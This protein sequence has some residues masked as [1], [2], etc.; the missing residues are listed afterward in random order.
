[1]FTFTGK[2]MCLCA[3][4]LKGKLLFAILVCFG[5]VPLLNAQKSPSQ[6]LL[7]TPPVVIDQNYCI[8]EATPTDICFS[9]SDLE[10]NP[11]TMVHYPG[12]QFLKAG[13]EIT[14]YSQDLMAST[15]TLSLN[16]SNLSTSYGFD[17]ITTYTWYILGTADNYGG[18]LPQ[19]PT[20][21]ASGSDVDVTGITP[22]DDFYV[23]VEVSNGTQSS[24]ASMLYGYGDFVEGGVIFAPDATPSF[25][26]STLTWTDNSDLFEANSNPTINFQKVDEFGMDTGGAGATLFPLFLPDPDITSTTPTISH[27]YGATTSYSSTFWSTDSDADPMDFPLGAP[28]FCSLFYEE[29]TSF[30]ANGTISGISTTSTEACFTYTPDPGFTGT[31]M[32]YF[33][34]CD[35]EGACTTVLVEFNVSA[36][37]PALALG[38]P[39]TDPTTCTGS[40]GVIT[41]DTSNIIDGSY[42]VNYTD[43][44]GNLQTTSMTVASDVGTLSGLAVGTYDNIKLEYGGCTTTS[45]IDVTLA[46]PPLPDATLT[47]SDPTTT[48]TESADIV[49]SNSEIGV[50]Y[51]LRLNSDNSNVG[52]PQAGTGGDLIFTVNPAVSTGYNILAT[53]DGTDCSAQLDDIGDVTVDTDGDGVPDHIDLDDDNDGI[54]DSV[55]DEN[56]DGDGDPTTNPTDTDSDGIPDYLDL[57]SDNDGI[58]DIIEAQTTTG[59]V[60]PNADTPTDYTTNNGVNSALLGGLTPED[61][62]GDGTP[63]YLD[64]DS[65][66]DGIFDIN[67]SGSGLVDA[68]TDGRTDGTVGVNGL[69]NTLDSGGTDDY[70]DVNGSFD[71]TQT[72][73]FTDTN[74][75]AG[76][77]GDVDYRELDASMMISQ[78]YNSSG[79]RAVELT[80]IGP[81]IVNTFVVAIFQDVSGDLTGVTP[82][83]TLTYTAGALSTFDS[84]VFQSTGFT[85]SNINNTPIEQT[86][87]NI[88]NFADGNDVIILTTTTDGTAWANRYDVIESFANNTSYVRNDD[89]LTTSLTF[90]ASDW[91]AFVDDALDPYRDAGSGGP[92]RHPHDPLLSEVQNSV[93]DRNQGLGY[94]RTNSTGITGGAWGNGEPDRSRRVSILEDYNHS[95]ST[96][97]ARRLIVDDDVTFSM[98]DNAIMV[99]ETITLSNSNSEIRLIG[100]S[101]LITTHTNTS[102]VSGDGRLLVD[103]NSTNPS[104]YRYNYMGSPVNTIGQTTFTVADVMKDGTV[105]TSVSSSVTD[106]NFISGFDG[107]GA[108]TPVS[109]AEYWIYSFGASA[110]WLQEMSSGTIPETDGFIF[111]GPGQTQN[112]TFAGTPK[113]GTMQTTVAASTSYLL[114][115]PFASAISTKKFIEDNLIATTG[116][117]YFW[118][119]KENINGEEDIFGHYYN[120][121]VGGYAIRNLSM[122]LAANAVTGGDVSTGVAGLGTGP[123]TEPA[124]YIAIG[125][126]FFIGGSGTG[127]TVEFNNSQ[128]EYIIE[129]PNS[130]FI[131]N[132]T[133]EENPYE[134]TVGF[135]LGMTYILEEEDYHRQIGISFL[136]TNSF[137]F[138]KGYDAEAFDL[139]ATDIYWDFPGDDTPYFIAGV[140][141]VHDS[142]QVPLTIIMDYDGD[143]KLTID[144][145]S[146]IHRDI[147]L[148]D[149]VDDITYTLGDDPQTLNLTLGIYEDRFFI[150]FGGS[151]L[152]NTN[153]EEIAGNLNCYVDQ[154]T[155][156]LVV[157]STRQ[158]IIPSQVF[159][160]DILGN[161]LQKWENLEAWNEPQNIRLKLRDHLKGVYLLKLKTNNGIVNK[162]I[163]LNLD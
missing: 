69:D 150:V 93:A 109:L 63:D 7:R 55:E 144:E 147:Y 119:Q 117:L 78:I 118:E 140:G 105:P 30:P 52:S 19:Y 122:G 26:G 85:G 1:M 17:P 156:H 59:Y 146:N 5:I 148:Y 67:E 87:D 35:D 123:Y 90:D 128:R 41:L 25:S 141:S 125:Q 99:S 82:T 4:A 151:E 97:S 15:A 20:S 6:E 3:G 113:D 127:G 98:T 49:L 108:T 66:N 11:F 84:V 107:D 112:Y 74:G 136:D 142:L 143:I 145:M 36:T 102:Q 163:Y 139:G 79:N 43:E 158:E 68:D 131:R 114:G 134:N 80:N 152:S 18:A 56:S 45:N 133:T 70:T 73:N 116:T 101:Q 129:G 37:V 71:D 34:I 62:D 103:Q 160:Y 159:L 53:I 75:N 65:D 40:D 104:L 153:D 28:Y 51:Q 94:H 95:G 100:N 44:L 48:A 32:A 46:G 121:Y 77:G 10:T 154:G 162:K 72:D 27:D 111:K 14:G 96:L 58:P 21:F 42:T 106:L 76:I 16:A 120:G 86:D 115:N 31:D 24:I 92:E 64:L 88:T 155:K 13:I 2:S 124:P 60:A 23:I 54:L 12:I 137:S 38:T 89:Q 9:V 126:G 47:V 149:S 132:T 81:S 157:K 135:K 138:D 130:I 57:D 22:E 161:Q 50:T 61:T 33:L 110:S 39:V 83:F 8:E 29:T 91:T